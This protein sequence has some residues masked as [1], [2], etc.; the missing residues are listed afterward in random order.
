MAV[1][2]IGNSASSDYLKIEA[3]GTPA[4]TGAATGWDDLRVEPTIK[5]TGTNDPAFTQWFTNGAGS[6]GV[7]LYEFTNSSHA[8]DTSTNT[9]GLL[10]ID[11]HYEVDTIGSRTEFTK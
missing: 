10:S 11:I 2:T 4:L 8:D 9:A 5:A 1:V 6:R 3:D 7:Y